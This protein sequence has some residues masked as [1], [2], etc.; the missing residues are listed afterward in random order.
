M[1]ERVEKFKQNLQLFNKTLEENVRTLQVNGQILGQEITMAEL[2]GDEDLKGLERLQE[3]HRHYCRTFGE[4][5]RYVNLTV[6]EADAQLAP[7]HEGPKG[8]NTPERSEAV[9]A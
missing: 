7:M 4:L 2:S 3:L 1:S 6:V 9:P 8:V 5:R